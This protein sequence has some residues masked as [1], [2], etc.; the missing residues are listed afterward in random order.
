MKL[1]TLTLP[2]PSGG[3]ITISPPPGVPSGGI[4]TGQ[5]IIGIA[6]N[7]LLLVASLLAISFIIYAGIQWAMSGGDKQKIQQS[8]QRL[9]FSIIG[10]IVI[11]AAFPIVNIVLSLLGAQNIGP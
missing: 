2:G 11:V 6:L 3:S 1:I 9:I 4:S 5:S 10:L 8:R 7:V